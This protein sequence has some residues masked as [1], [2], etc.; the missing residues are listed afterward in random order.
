MDICMT[1][2]VLDWVASKPARVRK[3]LLKE[4]GRRE[5]ENCADD[6]KY[7]MDATKHAVP[8]VYTKDPHPMY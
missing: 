7:W 6:V 4:L 3:A 1:Q 2:E 5:W 8:Y